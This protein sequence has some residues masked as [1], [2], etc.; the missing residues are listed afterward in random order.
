M[1]LIK[2]LLSTVAQN[3]LDTTQLPYGE[4]VI[5][6]SQ[7]FARLT[8][9]QAMLEHVPTYN[10][11]DLNN[12]EWL[13]KELKRFGVERTDGG[14]GSLQLALFEETAETKLIQPTFIVDYPA[15]V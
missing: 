14:L 3:E 4:H 8:V 2:E 10:E 15:E 11:I 1:E 12:R 5:D 7:P 13:V 9:V 6:L